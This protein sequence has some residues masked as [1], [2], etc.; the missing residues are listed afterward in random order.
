MSV[1]TVDKSK[2]EISKNFVAF[3]A[4]MNFTQT[5]QKEEFMFQNMAYK[6]TVY[7]TGAKAIGPVLSALLNEAWKKS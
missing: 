1:C 6:P 2:V 7:K 5:A 3:S 4:Y